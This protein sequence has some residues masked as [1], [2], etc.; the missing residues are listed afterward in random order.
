MNLCRVSDWLLNGISDMTSKRS[1]YPELAL[2][3]I[4]P[5]LRNNFEMVSCCELAFTTMLRFQNAKLCLNF[6]KC[7]KLSGLERAKAELMR[8]ANDPSYFKFMV[9]RHPLYRLTSGWNEKFSTEKSQFHLNY[10][11]THHGKAIK[12]RVLNL[13]IC[14]FKTSF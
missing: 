4:P 8:R 1:L 6:F 14:K 7:F 5:P 3:G 10:W 12:E 9:A 2:F 13:K 11:Q